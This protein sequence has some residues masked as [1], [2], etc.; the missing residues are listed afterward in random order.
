MIAPFIEQLFWQM[1]LYPEST[2]RGPLGSVLGGREIRIDEMASAYRGVLS[3]REEGPDT[4]VVT[5]ELAPEDTEIQTIVI[6]LRLGRAEGYW[7][8][9]AFSDLARTFAEL[10]EQGR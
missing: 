5:V 4:V 3:E 7:V 8:V 6:E 1:L 9:V 10:L 2:Q